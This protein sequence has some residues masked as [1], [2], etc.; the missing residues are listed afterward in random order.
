M[1]N[2]GM[3]VIRNQLSAK[4]I[5]YLDEETLKA[6][7]K[8]RDDF[9]VKNM[10]D[11]TNKL[12]M[13]Y[14][15]DYFESVYKSVPDIIKV[16]NDYESNIDVSEIEQAAKSIALLKTGTSN[17]YGSLD[18]KLNFVLN[19]R[20]VNA[21]VE[22]L[23][24]GPRTL[25]ISAFFRNMFLMYLSFP[26]YKRERIIYRDQI[27]KIESIIV[28]KEKLSY[29]NK[30][31]NET[32]ILNPYSIEESSHELYNYLIGESDNSKN[33][34]SI[35][36]NNLKDVVPVHERAVF[37]EKFKT[38]Y[39]RMKSNGIQF[40]INEEE[41]YYVLLSDK[42]YKNYQNRYLE[43]PEIIKEEM[44]GRYHKCYFNC[45]DFQIKN[46]FIPFDDKKNKIEI[47]T[48]K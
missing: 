36:L 38:N 31:K 37:S 29:V 7:R 27:A 47:K 21:A 10:N 42:Q 34:V 8:D 28:N 2:S 20:V 35:R 15:S 39:Q 19:K 41:T 14:V 48:V 3:D 33:T 6:L 11:F 12:V 4:I 18:K 26:S 22:A 40:G 25:D 1:N 17:S 9:K 5:V 45:S 30:E 23:F 43:R 46:Y 44:E 24:N 32:H 16:L 13:N